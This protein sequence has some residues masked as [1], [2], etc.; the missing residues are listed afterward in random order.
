MIEELAEEIEKAMHAECF[1]AAL[2]LALMLPDIC[3]KAEYPNERTGER[4]KK[5]YD[6]CV[7]ESEQLLRVIHKEEGNNIVSNNTTHAGESDIGK[8]EDCNLPYLSGDVVYSL[9]NSM[10]HQGTPNIDTKRIKV[11]DRFIL[12]IEPEN[13][14]YAYSDSSFSYPISRPDKGKVQYTTYEVSVRR[15]CEIL[16]R[17]ALGYYK[18]NKEKFDFFN[19]TIVKKD[20]IP[21]SRHEEL[22]EAILSGI[23]NIDRCEA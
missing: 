8:D 15:L 14:V 3:G 23:E 1:F 12:K 13:E 5:W 7:G 17:C 16:R 10:L 2:T 18:E 20:P 19:Y 4:Y 11:I 21:E 9:R 6:E 22:M